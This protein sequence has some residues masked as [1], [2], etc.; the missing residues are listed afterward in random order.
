MA[1]ARVAVPSILSAVVADARGHRE[2]SDGDGVPVI[3]CL[4][5]VRGLGG[6]G[7]SGIKT[8]KRAVGNV[9]LTSPEGVPQ[10]T[11]E[12]A[13]MVAAMFRDL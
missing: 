4:G 9:P 12:Q 6:T 2:R 5:G 1:H 10:V 3:L 7:S 8:G 13:L 11:N